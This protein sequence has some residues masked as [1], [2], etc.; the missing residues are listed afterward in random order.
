MVTPASASFRRAPNQSPVSFPEKSGP[1]SVSSWLDA[2]VEATESARAAAAPSSRVP[3]NAAAN[4][5]HPLMRVCVN[6]PTGFPPPLVLRGRVGVGVEGS[7]NVP[8]TVFI[9]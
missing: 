8:R 4:P 2:W 6:C 1:D 9:R 7:Q 3:K 5:S